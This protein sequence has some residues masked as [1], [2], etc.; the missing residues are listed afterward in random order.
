MSGQDL[1]TSPD[2]SSHSV[3]YS[4]KNPDFK[5][6]NTDLTAESSLFIT[7][8]S[9]SEIPG[10]NESHSSRDAHT[11][12]LE[13]ILA[14]ADVL[15]DMDFDHSD[16][17]SDIDLSL[18]DSKSGPRQSPFE[19]PPRHLSDILS[20]SSNEFQDSSFLNDTRAQFDLDINID[21]RKITPSTPKVSPW[22]N[23]ASPKAS[24]RQASYLSQ[25]N[26]TQ[27][28]S[29]QKLEELTKQ[30][31]NCKIQLKL[32]D[33][34]LQDLIDKHQIDIAD[35]TEFHE[36]L[37]EKGP[38]K[39][40]AEHAEMCAL[41]EDLY[42]S[43]EDYQAK[44]RDADRKTASLGQNLRETAL[45]VEELMKL[46]NKSVAS[47]PSDPELYFRETFP[48]L[49]AEILDLEASRLS[50]LKEVLES[51]QKGYSLYKQETAHVERALRQ[52]IEDSKMWKE[53]YQS[54]TAKINE[55]DY[56]KLQAENERLAAINQNVDARLQEYQVMIDRLQREVNEFRDVSRRSSS[57]DVSDT[58]PG[59]KDRERLLLLQRDFDIM[60][61]MHEDT[62]HEYERFREGA[63]NNIASLTNQLNNRKREILTLRAEHTNFENLQHDLEVAIEKQRV[64]TSEKIKLS[65][66]VESLSKDKSSLQTTINALTQKM[67]SVTT[68]KEDE[69]L[70]KLVS[71]S[72][73]QFDSMFQ[74]D[75]REFEKLLGSF[76]KIADDVSLKDPKRKIQHLADVLAEGPKVLGHP[77]E[78]VSTLKD[79][80]RSV[81][82][83]FAR[84]VDVIVNDHIRLLLKES[85]G[86]SKTSEY[87]KT[88][89]KR[90]AT[91]EKQNDD[92]TKNEA[93]SSP[94]NN[95]RIEELTNRWKAER[96]ARVYEN[97]Q[98]QKRLRELEQE[99]ARLRALENGV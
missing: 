24:I 82:S 85:E 94:K 32:Y 95:I 33:R 60:L 21:E 41:V 55:T 84:A 1:P 7:D 2:A 47:E 93:K 40:E 19:S 86:S 20:T 59:S 27:A 34:F 42:A 79:Y 37:E 71:Y 96:E 38:S 45:E 36:N 87:V 22:R 53:N 18:H 23:L 39:L 80:H 48:V 11:S 54:L 99:N 73:H 66:Q 76:N 56:K 77:A 72:E 15:H 35:L 62:V 83:Y 74:L 50:T 67:A 52:Q 4:G 25:R 70:R 75:V 92:I 57:I 29:S 97:R 28:E 44:W 81:F 78:V 64:L 30:L 10:S 88:L 46:L 26:I 13:T 65:Y 91:L 5:D 58:F 63:D 68:T 6:Q 90:I 51:L 49:R 43:L 9:R 14:P 98:A 17:E 61:R 3:L 12:K 69:S 8:P 89:Q 31:T 16:Y